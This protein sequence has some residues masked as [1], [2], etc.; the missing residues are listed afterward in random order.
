MQLW[1]QADVGADAPTEAA[2]AAAALAWYAAPMWW[3]LAIAVLGVVAALLLRRQRQAACAACA[4]AVAGVILLIADFLFPAAV[5]AARDALISIA[6][7][8]AATANDLFP[9]W[10]GLALAATGLWFALPPAKRRGQIAGAALGVLGLGLMTA[11]QPNVSQDLIARV[12]FYL[13]AGVTLFSAAATIT[14]RSP[15]YAAVWFAL[16]LLGVSGLFLYQG[17]QFL[18]VATIVVYAGAIVVTFLFVIMLAQPEGHASYDRISWG[19][20]ARLGGVVAAAAL[21]GAILFVI[22]QIGAAGGATSS[23]PPA[24]HMA[25]LGGELFGRHLVSIEV[26]GT[27]LLVALVGAVA[28]VIHGKSDSTSEDASRE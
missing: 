22:E 16:T 15:V 13:L 27:L 17:S 21:A 7:Q 23:E 11:G 26:A 5:G 2:A 6:G 20:A 14:M 3:G 9:S 19:W 25:R 12:V 4:T 8:L 28:I 18:G 24:D 10:W 1:A